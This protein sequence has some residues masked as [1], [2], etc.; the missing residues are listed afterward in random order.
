MKRVCVFCG[1]SFGGDPAY[2]QAARDLAVA[3]LEQDRE[4]VYGGARVGLMGILADTILGGGGNVRG[5]ITEA[6][7]RKV[8]HD[9]LT[10]QLVVPSM[11]ERKMAMFEMA[12]GFI[13]LPGGMGTLEEITEVVC[14]A[15]LGINPKPCGLLNVA[16]Y[17][18]AFMEFLDHSVR[19]GFMKQPHR[20]VLLVEPEPRALLARMASYKAPNIEKW[21]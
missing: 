16:G 13:A 2:A 9:G 3:L 12:D 19:Q 4:L 10:E 8:S 7:A 15:Q 1:S 18:D 5:I 11:H 17:Y 21:Q 20:D 14:W 6:L